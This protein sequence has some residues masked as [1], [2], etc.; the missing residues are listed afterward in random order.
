MTYS[1]DEEVDACQ[2]NRPHVIDGKQV[3]PK[4][5]KM[6]E[7]IDFGSFLTTFKVTRLFRIAR[8]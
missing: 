7:K 3:H 8:A 1:T 5:L 6:L 4:A 2:E